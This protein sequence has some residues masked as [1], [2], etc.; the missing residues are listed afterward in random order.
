MMDFQ[1]INRFISKMMQN[2]AIVTME[3]E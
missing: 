3:G 2:R 1:P